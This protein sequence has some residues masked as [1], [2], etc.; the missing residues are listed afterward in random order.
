VHALLTTMIVV[1]TSA[2]AYLVGTRALGLRPVA[3]RLVAAKV[4]ES[5]GSGAAFLL[6]NLA[7][8]LALLLALRVLTPWFL[9]LYLLE[10]AI[11]LPISLVQGLG[12]WWWR[13]LSRR[14]H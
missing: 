7:L 11:I 1:L 3:V 9:G 5:L 6:V 12:F 14:Q 13:E 2:T 8:G 4:V 10:D